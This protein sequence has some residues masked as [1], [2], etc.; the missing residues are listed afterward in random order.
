MGGL[1][2]VSTP[3]LTVLQIKMALNKSLASPQS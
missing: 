2:E 1:K 3:F